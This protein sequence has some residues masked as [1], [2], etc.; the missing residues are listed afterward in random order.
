MIKNRMV[1]NNKCVVD[2]IMGYNKSVLCRDQVGNGGDKCL[3]RVMGFS[4]L[5]QRHKFVVCESFLW[6]NKLCIVI[7]K[8]N[9]INTLDTHD[10]SCIS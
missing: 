1:G 5:K 4:Y 8:K 6:Q 2:Y 7:I 9:C 10:I 3:P